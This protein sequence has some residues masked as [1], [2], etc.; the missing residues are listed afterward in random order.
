MAQSTPLRP[1]A[2]LDPV[3]FYFPISSLVNIAVH[4]YDVAGTV[5]AAGG[6][7]DLTGVIP[8]SSFSGAV[9]D[10]SPLPLTE[11]IPPVSVI[12]VPGGSF[13]IFDLG[14]GAGVLKITPSAFI[15]PGGAV[16]YTIKCG[17]AQRRAPA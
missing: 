2:N 10:P 17:L 8:V 4:F 11:W 7:L 6:S 13:R 9:E 3:T 12:T 14:S 1:V 16:S 5:L 15:D